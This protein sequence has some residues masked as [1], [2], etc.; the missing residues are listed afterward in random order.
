MSRRVVSLLPAATEIV[1]ALGAGDDLVGRSHECD[2]PPEVGDVPVLTSTR[3]ADGLASG[4]I[5]RLVRE[6]LSIYDIDVEGLRRAGPDVILTQDLCEVCA[7]SYDD[8][9]R[10]AGSIAGKTVDVMSL[11]PTTLQG[12]LDCTIEVAGALGRDHRPLLSSLTA[13]IDAVS[14][15]HG[16]GDRPSVVALEWLGPCVRGGLWTEE[17]VSSA[18][19]TYLGPRRGEHA[20]TITRDE[21]IDLTPDVV[22]VKPCGFTLERT[23]S[24]AHLIP[25]LPST[26]RIYAAD[27]SAYFNRPGPRIVDS[28]EI[29][30]SMLHGTRFPD[31]RHADAWVQL[32]RDG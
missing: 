18:G 30:A 3:M 23:L 19:G 9:C 10:A 21:L 7:V 27:G 16:D 1:C 11:R 12:I 28:L 24:E 15:R 2:F 20:D 13:R 25:P 26:T 8:V 17:L 29:L 31:A 22:V 5:D 32:P 6:A 14:Q 4:E